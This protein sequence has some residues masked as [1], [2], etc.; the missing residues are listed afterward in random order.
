M[1]ET[2]HAEGRKSTEVAGSHAITTM[3][4]LAATILFVGLASQLFG[5]DTVGSGVL[6][7]SDRSSL[8][9]AFLLNIAV[10]LLGWRRS[11][12]LAQALAALDEAA[13]TANRNAYTDQMTGLSNRHALMLAL[14]RATASPQGPTAL[15]LLDL[16]HF[17]KVN[18]LHG[19]IRGD[20]LLM[21]VGETIRQIAPRGS[22][23]ARLGGDEFA[24]L[25]S[26][27]FDQAELVASAIVN[28]LAEPITLENFEAQISA[29]A[30]LAMVELGLAPEEL[31][32]RSDIAMYAAKRSG[33]NSLL[34]FD[35]TMEQQLLDRAQLEEEIRLGIERSEFVPY[36]Q[37]LMSLNGGELV[38]FEVLA[39]WHSPTRGLVEPV[40]FMNVA[41]A[42]GLIGKLSM[43]V[44]RAALIEARAWPAQ[45]KIAANISP[46]QFRDP[47]LAERVIQ[48]L[49]S[50]G[51]PAQRL[52]LEIT[53]GSLLED[54][55]LATTIVHS[56]KNAGIT[57][58]LDD[59]GTGYA[60]LSQLQALPFDRIKIDKSFVSALL[61]DQQSAMIVSAIASLGRSLS[62]PVTAEGVECEHVREQLLE[63]GCS[64]AQ[65]WLYGK[66]V[67]ADAVRQQFGFPTSPTSVAQARPDDCAQ[68]RRDLNRRA[69]PRAARL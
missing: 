40:D 1:P 14:R 15:M 44:M 25:L 43:S 57:I 50:T 66:A 51:F 65:G 28:R 17:K 55:E 19:H 35:A 47:Y 12:D 8:A 38:G 26:G 69:R 52:E 13:K 2:I 29:S 49:T 3:A 16:D 68:D 62:V 4:T 58:S 36:Y 24:V 27:D 39:R 21:S 33:R 64:D 30:G 22:C 60:S 31:L 53:E 18:D 61:R 67:P 23:C 32:H 54:R 5:Y 41:E 10:I 59:F 56:L 7:H 48:L 20:E 34:W 45:L 63:L 37:P 11:K 46:V 9:T 6:G 42:A